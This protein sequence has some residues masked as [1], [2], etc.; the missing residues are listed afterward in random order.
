MAYCVICTSIYLS[1]Y[2]C[3]TSIWQILNILY[4][5]YTFSSTQIPHKM[6]LANII[7]A[8]TH[9]QQ[10]PDLGA[11]PYWRRKNGSIVTLIF[12]HNNANWPLESLFN[13]RVELHHSYRITSTV[14]RDLSFSIFQSVPNPKMWITRSDR[15]CPHVILYKCLLQQC[16]LA[17]Y[18]DF[19]KPFVYT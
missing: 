10:R 11:I 4:Y 8:E 6:D 12:A 15:C 18:I 2:T 5:F 14:I 7:T 1:M 16:L 13:N 19:T 3:I 17:I 9:M